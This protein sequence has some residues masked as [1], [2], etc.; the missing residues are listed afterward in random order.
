ML[1]PGVEH[2]G[3]RLVFTGMLSDLVDAQQ[4]V[5]SN[6]A[7]Q[8]AKVRLQFDQADIASGLQNAVLTVSMPKN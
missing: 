7:L 5:W 2:Q 4:V 3:N 1:Q 8:G 6:T